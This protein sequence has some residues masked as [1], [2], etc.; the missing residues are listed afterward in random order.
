MFNT[1]KAIAD[2]ATSARPWRA[3]I[4]C[5]LVA[6]FS[7]CAVSA[8]QDTFIPVGPGS[9][10][11]GRGLRPQRHYKMGGVSASECRGV[12]VSSI[13][14][15]AYSHRTLQMGTALFL[16]QGWR[17]QRYLQVGYTGRAPGLM[18][19]SVAPAAPIRACATA[20]IHVQQVQAP[21]LQPPPPPPDD[22]SDI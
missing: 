12:C 8:D 15:S 19:W 6:F 1:R 17:K 9:C 18:T 14:C 16:E 21:P 13:H 22:M 11:D 2:P 7:P 20:R 10:L 5:T 4:A 3:F